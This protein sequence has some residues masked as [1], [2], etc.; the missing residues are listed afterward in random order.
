MTCPYLVF[1]TIA[2]AFAECMEINENNPCPNRDCQW[3]HEAQS[4][5]FTAEHLDHLEVYSHSA[6]RGLCR[7][8]GNGSCAAFRRCV[9]GGF[10][11]EDLIHLR[12][13]KHLERYVVCLLHVQIVRI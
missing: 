2:F 9:E 13:Y 8:G 7:N 6:M 12:V 11:T 10:T 1:F 3:F 5:C 4:G